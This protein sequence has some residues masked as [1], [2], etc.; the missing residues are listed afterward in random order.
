MLWLITGEAPDAPEG[1]A[2]EVGPEERSADV[3]RGRGPGARECTRASRES[4]DVVEGLGPQESASVWLTRGEPAAYPPNLDGASL[5]VSR[6]RFDH[7]ATVDGAISYCSA[8]ARQLSLDAIA[9]ATRCLKSFEYGLT[10]HAGPLSSMQLK[11][12]MP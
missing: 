7:F 8:I 1:S 12:R 4:G 3:S 6:T 5:P 2:A 9:A 11:S 10:M